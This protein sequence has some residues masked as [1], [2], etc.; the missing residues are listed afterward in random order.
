MWL[1]FLTART[2]NNRIFWDFP[3]NYEKY[4]IIIYINK[5]K[6][7]LWSCYLLLKIK[8]NSQ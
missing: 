8:Y 3:L 4:Y 2:K 7:K 5:D 1:I 6:K